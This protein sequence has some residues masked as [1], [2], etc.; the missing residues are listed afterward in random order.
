[1]R[2]YQFIAI[3]SSFADFDIRKIASGIWTE[4]RA[5]LDEVNLVSNG[6][7]AGKNCAV[8]TA[9]VDADAVDWVGTRGFREDAPAKKQV[10]LYPG[11]TVSMVE[12]DEV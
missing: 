11:V 3:D 7:T 5:T 8:V 12:V 10:K 9:E 6:K 1:M 2:L 4:E